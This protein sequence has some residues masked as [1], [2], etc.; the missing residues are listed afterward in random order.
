[1]E[2]DWK[3][4]ST[5]DRVIAGSA[6][7]AFIAAFLPWYGVSAGPFSASVSGWSAGFTAWAGSLLLVLA[8]VLVVLYRSGVSLPS[9]VD[10][11]LIVAAVAGLGLLLV[12]IRWLSFPT[13]QFSGVGYNVGA[14]F[15]IYLAL[16]VAIAEVT[17]AVMQFRRSGETVTEVPEPQEA[18][19]DAAP[20]PTAAPEETAAPEPAAT[21]E[22]TAPAE[23]EE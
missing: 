3:K 6:L 8:G 22:P 1:M 14:R 4:L 10:P 2:F 19:Q 17:A 13:Y 23:P 15:G 9:T 7:V 11:A 20:E 18:Q 16:I 21:P 5:L 12:V